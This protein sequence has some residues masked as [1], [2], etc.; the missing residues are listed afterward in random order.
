MAKSC[1]ASTEAHFHLSVI[2]WKIC[3]HFVSL[4]RRKIIRFQQLSLYK[5]V[6]SYV[7]T[8]CSCCRR[9]TQFMRVN[10]GCR[11]VKTW[12]FFWG[13]GTSSVPVND[14][15]TVTLCLPWILWLLN[16]I[17]LNIDRWFNQAVCVDLNWSHLFEHSSFF[18]HPS[19]LVIRTCLCAFVSQGSYLRS[20]WTGSKKPGGPFDEKVLTMHRRHVVTL[21]HVVWEQHVDPLV[22]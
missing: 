7:H 20:S 17:H 4:G 19:R 18:P 11:Q 2:S 22:L 15:E 9:W 1:T 8:K 21:H 13:G 12:V 10:M 14:Y 6:K 16:H 5:R 3:F